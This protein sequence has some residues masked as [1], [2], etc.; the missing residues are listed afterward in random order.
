[1]HTKR[2]KV[3]AVVGNHASF[4]VP[5]QGFVLASLVL[6]EVEVEDSNSQLEREREREEVLKSVKEIVLIG[7][8]DSVSDYIG[9]YSNLEELIVFNPRAILPCFAADC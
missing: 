6:F 9:I 4:Q 5:V 8:Y 3:V 1:M 2:R 7:S